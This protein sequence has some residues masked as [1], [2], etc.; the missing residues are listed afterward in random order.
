MVL[1][2]DYFKY[3]QHFRATVPVSTLDSDRATSNLIA[4]RHDVDYD[5][6]LAL[7]MAW[8]EARLGFKATYFV[9][10]TASYW[11]DRDFLDKCLQVQDF[12][13]EIGLHVNILTEWM[14]GRI[15]DLEGA[16]EQILKPLKDVGV[17]VVGISSHGDKACYRGGFIN[18]WCFKEFRPEDPHNT[19]NGLSAEGIP[20]ETD[21]FRIRYPQD[22]ELI[23]FD[24]VR[25]PLWSVSSQ[26]LG[27]RYNA[28]QVPCDHYFTDSGGGWKR[29]ADPLQLSLARGRHQVL[30]HPSYW[31][32]PK[33]VF[34]F[35][36]TA[37]SGS[38][39]LATLSD[40]ATSA[41]GRHEFSLNHFLDGAELAFQKRTGSNFRQLVEERG[42]SVD[43]LADIREWLKGLTGDYVEANVYLEQFLPELRQLF[44][45]ATFI[46]LHR[47]PKAVVRSLVNR[48]WYDT[49]DDDRHP[50]VEV[51]GWDAMDQFHKICWY[52]RE[53][54]E[55][56][57]RNCS[58]HLRFEDMV[59][60]GDSLRKL[61]DDLDLAYYPRLAK[62]ILGTRINA[63]ERNEFPAYVNWNAPQK[64]V[65]QQICGPVRRQLLYLDE[66]SSLY[67]V[68]LRSTLLLN[69][70][71]ILLQEAFTKG[72]RSQDRIVESLVR[73]SH[74]WQTSGCTLSLGNS[75]IEIQPEGGR[76]AYVLLGGGIW[77]ELKPG[78]GWPVRR[79]HFCQIRLEIETARPDAVQLFCL[80]YDR[81]GK[82]DSKR[83]LGFVDGTG[84][85]QRVSFRPRPRSERFDLS[86]HMARDSL[87][88]R[89]LVRRFELE[90]IPLTLLVQSD[91][92]INDIEVGGGDKRGW[93]RQVLCRI[94]T[95]LDRQPTSREEEAVLAKDRQG[96]GA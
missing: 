38:K 20:G 77:R 52:V 23:R 34:F 13:H 57:A 42:E 18:Y 74:R 6:D 56:L 8:G 22:E 73:S 75:G 14:E 87:P 91:S 93:M 70:L 61:F 43:L 79:G 45:K 80:S 69:R 21:A 81:A 54:N 27:L 64:S 12:G 41:T 5:L 65:F 46:H 36:S 49:P 37:R 19:E 55:R 40:R 89:C 66:S 88:E 1:K 47:D 76:H 62:P 84:R 94:V 39:W 10:H 95:L 53:T 30:M 96:R 58:R 9:L 59:S 16:L 63:N 31:R 26:R 28:S 24:K 72:A 71:R 83:S 92:P 48:D 60:H 44:P 90:A 25:F 32:G 85:I 82:L 4:L 2:S 68:Y 7:E 29:S 86:L 50:A 51:A 33:R 67:R 3:L 11:K 15:S 35:L 17:S 78:Q